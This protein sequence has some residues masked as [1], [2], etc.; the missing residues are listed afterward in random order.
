MDL[1]S[2]VLSEVR[3]RRRNAMQHPLHVEPKR[4]GASTLITK[5]KETHRL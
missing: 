3:Q 4:K 2:A 1:E 5:Q